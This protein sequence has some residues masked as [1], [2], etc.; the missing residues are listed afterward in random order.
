MNDYA[1]QLA[2]YRP[3]TRAEKVAK[4]LRE[5]G[6]RFTMIPLLGGL[7][8][9]PLMNASAAV[10]ESVDGF[11]HRGFSSGTKSLI[12][13]AVDTTVT[14][15]AALGWWL[16]TN[17]VAALA[18]GDSLGELAR[19]GTQ[20]LL[21][22]IIPD[23]PNK[24]EL[25]QTARQHRI[26]GMMPMT[27]GYVPAAIGYAPGIDRNIQMSNTGYIAPNGQQMPANH[28]SDREAQRRGQD[29]EA[30]R[31]AWVRNNHEDAQ[32]LRN[33]S[34]GPNELGA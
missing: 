16:P 34:Q 5:W 19:K 23:G 7:L 9:F 33:A 11:I 1:Q 32:A 17:W 20:G 14:S 13:G 21:D 27:T 4:G 10:I 8:I 18:T 30:A 15:I 26:L 29:P 6:H 31:Q 2:D 28:W 22:T 24:S 25:T 12:S 3:P